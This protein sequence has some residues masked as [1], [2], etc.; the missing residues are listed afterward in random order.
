[1]S[2]TTR[3]EL[4]RIRMRPS[5]RCRISRYVRGGGGGLS[6]DKPW[7]PEVVARSTG[8]L[9]SMVAVEGREAWMEGRS[10]CK[11]KRAQDY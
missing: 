9:A 10:T 3:I 8:W 11:Y 4:F 6:D 7:L 1:M 2:F 5:R